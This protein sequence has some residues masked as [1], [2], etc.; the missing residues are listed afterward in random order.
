VGGAARV[1]VGAEDHAGGKQLVRVRWWPRVPG[2]GPILAAAFAGLTILAAQAHVWGAAVALGLGVVLPTFHMVEQ[3]MA[4]MA[5]IRRALR[6]L[7]WGEW[8]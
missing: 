3:A 4:G 6:A 5:A 7:E 1:L 8:R 2:R